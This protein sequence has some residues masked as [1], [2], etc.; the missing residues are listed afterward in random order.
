MGSSPLAEKI[1]ETIAPPIFDLIDDPLIDFAPGSSR[2]DA[3][4]LARQRNPLVQNGVLHG[5]LYDLDAASRA[6]KA[7]TASAPG[8]MPTNLVLS[9]GSTPYRNILAGIREGLLVRSVMGLGQGNV[10]NGDFSLNVL[11]GYKIENGSI[12]GRVKDVM[13]AGN[14]Y[15]ALRRIEV[16]SLEQ[17]TVQAAGC[18]SLTAPYV[19]VDGLSIA[20]R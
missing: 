13:L 16:M 3:D 9:A 4:G 5:F 2:Y 7:S 18:A 17:E 11:L 6:N 1:G 15:D 12:V 10:I 20:T 14:A 8:C 19:L